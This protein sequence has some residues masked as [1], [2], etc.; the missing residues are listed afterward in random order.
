MA[1]LLINA[2][3][4][5]RTG[6]NILEVDSLL[7]EPIDQHWKELLAK[8]GVAATLHAI[9]A[10]Q[11]Q[12]REEL[13]PLRFPENDLMLRQVPLSPAAAETVLLTPPPFCGPP[14]PFLAPQERSVAVPAPPMIDIHKTADWMFFGGEPV[15]PPAEWTAP[16]AVPPPPAHGNISEPELFQ[17]MQMLSLHPI[18]DCFPEPPPPE[19]GAAGG[20]AFEHSRNPT[21][22][23]ARDDAYFV[24]SSF[25]ENLALINN[26]PAEQVL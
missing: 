24:D 1:K 20:S 9:K 17:M 18:S 11:L 7:E 23:A 6:L 22:S 5:N 14:P 10:T 15:T 8:Y 26:F 16:V 25:W 4:E 3:I 12:Q 19:E 2:H 13:E 21:Q